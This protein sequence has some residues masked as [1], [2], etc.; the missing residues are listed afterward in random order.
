MPR[1]NNEPLKVG[2]SLHLSPQTLD[3]IN[4][5]VEGKSLSE[6]IRKV[7]EVG[8]EANPTHHTKKG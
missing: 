6:K 2:I 1:K 8:L 5:T 7:I 3:I 4:E